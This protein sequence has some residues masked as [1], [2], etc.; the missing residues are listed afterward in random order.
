LF[1]SISH[2]PTL[3]NIKNDY[4]V[5]GEREGIIGAKIPVH[6]RYALDKK[7]KYYKSLAGVEYEDTE[8]DWREIIYRMAM[9]Y[10]KH[11]QEDDFIQ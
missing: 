3:N 9:D 1:V 5:W 10:Y 11:N 6:F 7:P 4:S 2:T 8:Y